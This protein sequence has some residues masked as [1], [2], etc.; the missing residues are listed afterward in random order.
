[1]VN[2][3]ERKEQPSRADWGVETNKKKYKNEHCQPAGKQTTV[4]KKR[5]QKNQKKN[6]KNAKP[7]ERNWGLIKM[8]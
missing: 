8:K 5:E 3:R 1:M 4:R 6:K 2:K 7:C